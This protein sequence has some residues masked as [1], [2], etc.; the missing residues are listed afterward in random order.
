MPPH[1]REASTDVGYRIHVQNSENEAVRPDS[2]GRCIECG[3]I[4]AVYGSN[5]GALHPAGTD[6][7]C[8]CGNDTFREIS[9]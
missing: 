3:S 1:G 7:R 5:A 6:G 2:F 4:Y 8:K 9:G